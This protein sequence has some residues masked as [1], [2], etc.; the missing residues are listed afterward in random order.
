M[1]SIA[2]VS[3]SSSSDLIQMLQEL[4]RKRAEAA[5]TTTTTQSSQTDTSG[6]ATFDQ[7]FE[8]ALV[9]AGLDSSKMDEVKNAIKSA[10]S[11]A[12][13]SAD[14]TTDPREAVGQAIDETLQKY[15][16]DT[17]KLKEKMQSM[18]PQGPPP[19]GGPG[20]PNG[21]DDKMTDALTAAGVD[22]SKLDEIKSAIDQAVSSV[23]KD[24]S[25]TDNHEAVKSAVHDVLD[26]YGVDKAAFDKEMESDMGGSSSQ[27]QGTGDTSTSGLSQNQSLLSYLDTSSSSTD[28]FQWYT[29]LLQF[30]DEQA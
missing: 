6:R 13:S 30:V 10:V 8:D 12:L 14:G 28:S 4:A 2:G 7:G 5:D 18:R 1:T 19:G 15:G 29:G 17:D 24:S 25:G 21:G 3:G 9:S 26:K 11:T 27:A 16:V 22:S 23:S 20:G